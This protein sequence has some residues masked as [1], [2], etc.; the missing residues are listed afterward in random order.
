DSIILMNESDDFRLIIITSDKPSEEFTNSITNLANDIEEKY[1]DL[2]REFKGG[3][4]TQFTGIS[5]LIEKHLN[6]SFA[7]P[8]KIAFSKKVKLNA[9][10]KSVIEKANEIM[11]QTNLNYFYTTFLMPN[12]QFD[13]ETT[14]VIFNLIEKKIFQPIN[15]NLIQ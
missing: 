1:G 6:V 12:Q 5:K 13:L 10:E 4:V 8:L 7:S 3:M 14:K 9:M 15:L 2:L 11:K